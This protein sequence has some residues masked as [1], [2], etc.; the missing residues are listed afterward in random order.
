MGSKNQKAIWKN[1]N[2]SAFQRFQQEEF[3]RDY[4]IWNLNCLREIPVAKTGKYLQGME[5]TV[6][7]RDFNDKKLKS[8]EKDVKNIVLFSSFNETCW[9]ALIRTLFKPY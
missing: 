9:K 5:I 1:T 7:Y 4:E 8:T 2:P 6:L 3:E